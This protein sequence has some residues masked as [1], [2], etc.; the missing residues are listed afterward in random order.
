MAGEREALFSLLTGFGSRA[1]D[2]RVFQ[3]AGTQRGTN[4]IHPSAQYQDADVAVLHVRS[5]PNFWG[6]RR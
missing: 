3:S 2:A 1:Q 6:S 4:R 5:L